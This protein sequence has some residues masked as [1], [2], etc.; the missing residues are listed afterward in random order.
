ML[1]YKEY[2]CKQAGLALDYHFLGEDFMAD[3]IDDKKIEH[4]AYV[5]TEYIVGKNICIVEQVFKPQSSNS[6]KEI[7]LRLLNSNEEIK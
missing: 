7:I 1:L 2:R 5:K 6:L 4:N 3:K